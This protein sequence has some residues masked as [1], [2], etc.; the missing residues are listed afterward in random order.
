MGGK[1]DQLY[2]LG[3]SSATAS[4]L[5]NRICLRYLIRTS[6]MRITKGC[7]GILDLAMIGL[8]RCK[9]VQDTQ[10]DEVEC[11]EV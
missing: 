5:S 10:L 11:E 3:Q 4:L 6:G 7:L 1:A 8:S 9:T 2:S